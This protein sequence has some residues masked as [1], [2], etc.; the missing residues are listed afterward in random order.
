M[1]YRD[2][3]KVIT[4]NVR[5]DAKYLGGYKN[6]KSNKKISIGFTSKK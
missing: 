1:H 3:L 2:V 4:T 5:N 6:E